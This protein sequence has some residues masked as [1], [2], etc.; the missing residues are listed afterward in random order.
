MTTTEVK[1]REIKARLRL[2]GP[3]WSYDNDSYGECIKSSV[4]RLALP[5]NRA[6]TE[7]LRNSYDDIEYLLEQLKEKA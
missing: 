5:R 6:L 4:G 1:I 3:I 2:V 7:F